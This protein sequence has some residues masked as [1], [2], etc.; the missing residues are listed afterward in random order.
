MDVLGSE[1]EGSFLS[2]LRE[3]GLATSIDVEAEENHCYSILRLTLELQPFNV[4]HT[5]ITLI[6]S[7]LFSYLR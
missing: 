7:S 2:I 3:Q 6:G 5:A 1:G 4:N